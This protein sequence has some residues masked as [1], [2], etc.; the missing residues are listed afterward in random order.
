MYS[1]PFWYESYSDGVVFSLL[2]LGGLFPSVGFMA[3]PP[4]P[5][6]PGGVFM[7]SAWGF[8]LVLWFLL[9]FGGWE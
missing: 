9:W 3:P 4:P 1:Y 7:V 2:S 6:R 8:F 5:R